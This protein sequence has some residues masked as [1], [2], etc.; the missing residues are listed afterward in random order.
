MAKLTGQELIDALGA[1]FNRRDTLVREIETNGRSDDAVQQR[2]ELVRRR[3][4]LKAAG[5]DVPNPPRLP[6]EKAGEKPTEQLVAEYAARRIEILTRVA[7]GQD[8]G[9]RLLNANERLAAEL[10]ARDLDAEREADLLTFDPDRVVGIRRQLAE[11]VDLAPPAA[12]ERSISERWQYALDLSRELRVIDELA[13]AAAGDKADELRARRAEINRELEAENLAELSRQAYRDRFGDAPGIPDDLADPTT[14]DIAELESRRRLRRQSVLRKMADELRLQVAELESSIDPEAPA[15]DQGFDAEAAPV[16]ALIANRQREQLARGRDELDRLESEID[17]LRYAPTEW[18]PLND[19]A[20]DA[21]AFYTASQ[22]LAATRANELVAAELAGADT[23]QYRTLRTNLDIANAELESAR[24]LL[25]D[26]VREAQITNSTNDDAIKR[27]RSL[28][29]VRTERSYLD[30]PGVPHRFVTEPLYSFEQWRH[31]TGRPDYSGRLWESSGGVGPDQAR[32]ESRN[33]RERRKREADR[34]LSLLGDQHDTYAELVKAGEIPTVEKRVPLARES[35]TAREFVQ[36]QARLLEKWIGKAADG[37]D[38]ARRRAEILARKMS[39]SRLADFVADDSI[40]SEREDAQAATAAARRIGEL[41]DQAEALGLQARAPRQV[42]RHPDQTLPDAPTGFIATL[43]D[44]PDP[45]LYANEVFYSEDGTRRV[46]AIYRD[47]QNGKGKSYFVEALVPIDKGYEPA[48]GPTAGTKWIEVANESKLTRAGAFEL[49]AQDA[50]GVRSQLSADELRAAA[51]AIPATRIPRTIE[52]DQQTARDSLA[53][54]DRM[55]SRWNI[56]PDR[57]AETVNLGFGGELPFVNR[58]ILGRT[59]WSTDKLQVQIRES[60]GTYRTELA[61]VRGAFAI[62]DSADKSQSESK[63]YDQFVELVH[64]PTGQVIKRGGRGVIPA[65]YFDVGGWL[66]D[67]LKLEAE[68]LEPYLDPLG[69]PAPGQ[70]DKFKKAL[71]NLDSQPQPRRLTGDEQEVHDEFFDWLDNEEDEPAADES[72]IREPEPTLGFSRAQIAEIEDKFAVLHDRQQH[73]IDEIVT[74]LAGR[75]NA[76][77]RAGVD[78]IN[79]DY[80]GGLAVDKQGRFVLT[81]DNVLVGAQVAA[82]QAFMDDEDGDIVFREIWEQW[83]R[84]LENIA[85]LVREYYDPDERGRDT[86]KIWEWTVARDPQGKLQPDGTIVFD[87]PIDVSEAMRAINQF[88]SII[89]DPKLNLVH[90]ARIYDGP[91]GRG[92]LSQQIAAVAA[93]EQIR[94]TRTGMMSEAAVQV[95]NATTNELA[96]PETLQARID[97]GLWRLFNMDGERD[98]N[99]E[100]IEPERQRNERI[101]ARMADA[102]LSVTPQEAA[103]F[104]DFLKLYTATVDALNGVFDE[105]LRSKA[106]RAADRLKWLTENEH[107]PAIEDPRHYGPVRPELRET[108]GLYLAKYREAVAAGDPNAWRYAMA[109]AMDRY[110]DGELERRE[111]D[112]EEYQKARKRADELLGRVSVVNRQFEILADYLAKVSPSPAEWI[113]PGTGKAAADV[114]LD[115]GV[116]VETGGGF[117]SE[118]SDVFAQWFSAAR[119]HEAA[120]R[121]AMDA[122]RAVKAWQTAATDV[123]GGFVGTELAVIDAIKGLYPDPGLEAAIARG[124]V[125]GGPTADGAPY[126]P[127]NYGRTLATAPETLPLIFNP[128]KRE[129]DLE[130]L[131][132]VARQVAAQSGQGHA[133]RYHQLTAH[134][135]R[136]LADSLV[137]SIAGKQSPEQTREELE[138]TLGIVDWQAK[139]LFH[140]ATQEFSREVNAAKAEAVDLKY[141]RYWGPLDG[142]TRPFCRRHVGKVF[143]LDEINA[144]DNRQTGRGS[145]LIAAG[146]YNCRHHWRGVSVNWYT[147]EQWLALRPDDPEALARFEEWKAA[148]AEEVPADVWSQEARMARGSLRLQGSPELYMPEQWIRGA[149]DPV[150][151]EKAKLAASYLRLSP[152]VAR[153]Y[154]DMSGGIETASSIESQWFRRGT[155]PGFDFDGLDDERATT[156]D[157]RKARGSVLDFRGLPNEELGAIVAANRFGLFKDFVSL[158]AEARAL[159]ETPKEPY[160]HGRDHELHGSQYDELNRITAIGLGFESGDAG[161]VPERQLKK[162]SAA[163]RSLNVTARY[164][165]ELDDLIRNSES[166]EALFAEMERRTAGAVSPRHK[167]NEESVR[168]M[169]EKIERDAADDP[170]WA[171][172]DSAT[173][174]SI[175]RSIASDYLRTYYGVTGPEAPAVKAAIAA[176]EFDGLPTKADELAGM[177]KLLFGSHFPAN[178]GDIQTMPNQYT[179]LPELNAEKNFGPARAVWSAWRDHAMARARSYK[180][181]N[182]LNL[183]VLREYID[184]NAAK[185]TPVTAADVASHTDS[186][187]KVDF[188]PMDGTASGTFEAARQI[189]NDNILAGWSPSHAFHEAFGPVWVAALAEDGRPPESLADIDPAEAGPYASLRYVQT[190]VLPAVQASDLWLG[191]PGEHWGSARSDNDYACA[192][193]FA[194]GADWKPLDKADSSGELVTSETVTIDEKDAVIPPQWAVTGELR[195]RYAQRRLSNQPFSADSRQGEK[196]VEVDQAVVD[197][198]AA[199]PPRGDS[200]VAWLDEN[201]LAY[202]HRDEI[203]AELAEHF[204]TSIRPELAGLEDVSMTPAEAEQAIIRVVQAELKAATESQS[205]KAQMDAIYKTLTG[206]TDRETDEPLKRAKKW[207]EAGKGFDTY[208]RGMA[209]DES[210]LKAL[211]PG[212]SMALTGAQAFSALRP[213]AVHYADSDWTGNIATGLNIEKPVPIVLSIKRTPYADKSITMY[214]PKFSDGREDSKEHEPPF[215]VL[216]AAPAIRITSR[217][218]LKTE[219]SPEDHRDVTFWEVQ[220]EFYDPRLEGDE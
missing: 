101:A 206:K 120:E 75:Y 50:E 110:G 92:W 56:D 107:E 138:K 117:D 59:T 139:Q 105:E 149:Y 109:H 141:F 100:M 124:Q 135:R 172:A 204:R 191:K 153:A 26:Y 217:P 215:E 93:D 187:T 115:A 67:D 87:R 9:V 80:L 156:L 71:R 198:V 180:A 31:L 145:V 108:S 113:Y 69:R 181:E 95:L 137:R 25:R 169:R 27:A 37:D 14:A 17:A 70:R 13:K 184:F 148:T 118:M 72:T 52:I 39:D 160:S 211:E 174:R 44:P 200:L 127:D 106:E 63:T 146:G 85:E 213:V 121:R 136:L 205:K 2:A 128:G 152:A 4:E 190:N 214:H 79:R 24:E 192:A 48:T 147:P 165:R 201:I 30:D 132:T 97:T 195:R 36:S 35:G 186:N 220:G 111:Y 65:R 157:I 166:P 11:L 76:A 189:Y 34:L 177:A 178:I 112:A 78:R 64:V 209:Y 22:T 81:E 43:A 18:R 176:D 32:K 47:R 133:A 114:A 142:I 167:Q 49:A 83:D 84:E 159:T 119:E 207:T 28:V 173:R 94:R 99:D 197:A 8:P 40:A 219:F 179:E 123:R 134:H 96:G 77:M 20:N 82:A 73:K 19:R 199:N 208:F 60:D 193:A 23:K 171:G 42:P 126:N 90:D 41:I 54:V 196:F 12:L 29:E 57:G 61:T 168:S 170:G 89:A 130:G 194:G 129:P 98:D 51:E 68:E 74:M 185:L 162:N 151:A 58:S 182:D 53:T 122:N 150:D 91:T 5:Q 131:P 55:L 140:D 216:T 163:I 143:T 218:V 6:R 125:I 103:D 158:Y 212:S 116:A 188:V 38:D 144:L 88:R 102:G 1:Y 183:A 33:Q 10:A 154:V 161:L 66:I 175:R 155:N 203:A 3:R 16:A 15:V 7:Q 46:T 164:A 21:I 86:A 104:Y 62:V 202:R 45:G 210:K